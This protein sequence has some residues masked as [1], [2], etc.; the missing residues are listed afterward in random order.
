MKTK[1]ILLALLVTASAW[2]ELRDAKEAMKQQQ[3]A[4]AG[5]V[6]NTMLQQKPDDPWLIYD[7]GVVAY[8]QKDYDKADKLWQELSTKPL[9][10][11]LQDKVWT[12]VGNVSFRIGEA[13]VSAT[14]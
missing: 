2:A 5:E 6:I 4:K 14:P 7:A 12:Q 13:K 8:A 9:P 3:P 11:Q 1:L 10:S